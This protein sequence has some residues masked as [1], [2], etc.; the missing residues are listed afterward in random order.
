MFLSGLLRPEL[1]SQAV[2]EPPQ[3]PLVL[4][5]F[6]PDLLHDAVNDLQ[7]TIEF[8]LLVR[9]GLFTVAQGLVLPFPQC[10]QLLLVRLVGHNLQQVLSKARREGAVTAGKAWV[11][12]VSGA[13]TITREGRCCEFP[14]ITAKE[15]P[16]P[17]C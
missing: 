5:L 14:I 9:A 1:G 12:L 15:H 13:V 11:G 17:G 2:T 16:Q 6:H 7:S 10:L 3:S 4:G 8:L